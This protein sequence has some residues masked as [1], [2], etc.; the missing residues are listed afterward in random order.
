MPKTL[1]SAYITA[2][3]TIRL[4]AEVDHQHRL[5]ADVPNAVAPGK[6]EIDLHIPS[7]PEE[8]SADQWTRGI[9]QAWAEDLADERQDIYSA[10]DGEPVD[11]AR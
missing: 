11:D 5:V 1:G 7:V 2:M 4:T 6:V 10:D 8:E 9:A 3:K